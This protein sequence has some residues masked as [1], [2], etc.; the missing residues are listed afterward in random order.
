MKRKFSFTIFFN[1]KD[2]AYLFKYFY[3]LKLLI[4]QL[5]HRQCYIIPK[6]FSH[7]FYLNHDSNRRLLINA[8]WKR[9]TIYQNQ[10]GITFSLTN[11]ITCLKLRTVILF[12]NTK[13][14][15]PKKKT[16]EKVCT[17]NV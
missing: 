8:G 11:C 6:V 2:I 3:T 17:I 16:Q 4:T 10:N 13:Y 7:K 15:D 12:S 1:S 14:F 5:T 9:L